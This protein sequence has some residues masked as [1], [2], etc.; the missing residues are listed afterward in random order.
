MFIIHP[1]HQVLTLCKPFYNESTPRLSRHSVEGRLV[2]VVV[3]GGG[4]V[5][6]CQHVTEVGREECTIVSQSL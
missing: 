2:V 1:P 3:V 6:H 5:V 4:G